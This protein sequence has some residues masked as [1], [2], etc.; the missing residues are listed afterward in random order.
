MASPGPPIGTLENLVELERILPGSYTSILTIH[1]GG[2]RRKQS[3]AS[4]PRTTPTPRTF[5]SC[6][7]YCVDASEHNPRPWVR[8]PGMFYDVPNFSKVP[9]FSGRL[10]APERQNGLSRCCF[11]PAR[12]NI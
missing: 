12:K 7:L 8:R 10:L 1:L 5:L 11:R 4:L 9:G 3:T 6:D 2:I